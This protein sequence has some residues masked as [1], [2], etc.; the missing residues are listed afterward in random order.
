M[1]PRCIYVKGIV[2]M[3]YTYSVVCVYEYA[4]IY[5]VLVPHEKTG[6]SFNYIVDAGLL[7]SCQLLKG[8]LSTPYSRLRDYFPSFFDKLSVLRGKNSRISSSI[9]ILQ[10][11]SVS[12]GE[13]V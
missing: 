11:L 9:T 13:E 7:S 2:Y 10:K 1:S 6:N 4:C 8:Y 12:V 5:T 3:V